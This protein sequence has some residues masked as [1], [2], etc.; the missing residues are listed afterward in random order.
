MLLLGLIGCLAFQVYQDKIVGPRQESE[1][2]AIVTALQEELDEAK[3]ELNE[4]RA[5]RP[6]ATVAQA[7]APQENP[8][9]RPTPGAVPKGETTEERLARER[10]ENEARVA[11]V[12]REQAARESRLAK[13][14]SSYKIELAKLDAEITKLQGYVTGWRQREQEAARYN[15]TFREQGLTSAGRRTGTRT[16]DAD[17]RKAYAARDA[18]VA[19]CRAERAKAEN[20]VTEA[21]ARRQALVEIYSTQRQQILAA[22]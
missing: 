19:Q 1:Q 17:R 8:A 3:A 20:A 14:D 7:P 2:A 13:L 6:P 16:S 15:P 22:R 12:K 5:G 21:T 9:P 4:A 10:A 18:N 11:A